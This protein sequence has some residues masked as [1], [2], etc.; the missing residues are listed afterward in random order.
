MTHASRLQSK[1]IR[2]NSC[3]ARVA[4]ATVFFCLQCR[5]SCP[6]L[7]GSDADHVNTVLSS[8]SLLAIVAAATL[9]NVC[10]C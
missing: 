2:T 6:V 8:K 7:G 1:G 10:L 4:V 5:L 9:A 3:E